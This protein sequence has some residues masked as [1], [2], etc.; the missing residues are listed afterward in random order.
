MLFLCAGKRCHTREVGRA[1]QTR[2]N[3]QKSVLEGDR[4]GG[5]ATDFAPQP[6]RQLEFPPVPSFRPHVAIEGGVEATR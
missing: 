2:I 3:E 4:G 5:A 1:F 6:A